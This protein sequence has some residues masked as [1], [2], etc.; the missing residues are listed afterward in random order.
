M[1]KNYAWRWLFF[2]S[3][4][5]VMSLGIS[6]TIKGQRLGIAPWDVLH[7]GLY[8]N[9][10]LTIGTWGILTGL[11]IVLST[12]AALRQWPKIGTWINMIAIGLFIDLF[13]WLLPDVASLWG[14]SV[15]YILGIIVMSYGLGIYVSP[16]M[17]AG[18]RDS[19]MLI[20]VEKLGISIKMVRTI[21]EIV[22]ALLGWLL[23]GPIGVGTVLIALLS[24]QIV[25]YA[26]PQCRRLLLKMMGETDERVLF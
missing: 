6:M 2:V 5:M 23:G 24:G 22:V 25:H 19:L 11:F 7:V 15:I 9:F 3:G 8:Q 10:G 16:N 4:L 20:L 21:I 13:N 14:Q 12:A 17:G 26:L 1:R 18:P